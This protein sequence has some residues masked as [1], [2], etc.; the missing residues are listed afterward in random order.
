MAML[1][2]DQRGVLTSCPS[3]GKMNRLRYSTLESAARCGQCH[4]ALPAA[5]A[6]I[7]VPDEA[8][9][10]ALV[11]SAAIPV[12]VDFWA[13]WCGPCHMMAPELVA[14]ARTAAGTWLVVKVNTEAIPALGER[15]RIRSIPTLAVLQNGRELGRAPGARRAA[16]IQAVVSQYL[17]SAGTAAER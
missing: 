12:V 17:P 11:A 6:P 14:A 16:D 9:F 8:T 3:C 7:E 1:K 13:P 10:D 15:F 2:L 4:T 5:D